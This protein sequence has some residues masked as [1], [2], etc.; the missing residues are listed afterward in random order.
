MAR[1]Y[2]SGLRGPQYVNNSNRTGMSGETLFAIWA[3]GARGSHRRLG[4][5]SISHYTYLIRHQDS[6]TTKSS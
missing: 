1:Q 3:A 4:H 6:D 2:S 5:K